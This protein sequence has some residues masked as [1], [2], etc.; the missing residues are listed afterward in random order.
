MRLLTVLVRVLGGGVGTAMTPIGV[1]GAHAGRGRTGAGGVGGL[2]AFAGGGFR[3][4]LL[5]DFVLCGYLAAC[6]HQ[7]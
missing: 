7:V 6:L 5:L 4:S 3:G 1:F 2:A